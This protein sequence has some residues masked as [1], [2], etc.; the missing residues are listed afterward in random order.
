MFKP[1]WHRTRI[2]TKNYHKELKNRKNA[3]FSAAYKGL[4]AFFV[5]GLSS[6]LE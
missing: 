1:L 6:D 3:I 5:K 4:P 2:C